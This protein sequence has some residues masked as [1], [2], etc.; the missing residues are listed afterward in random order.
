VCRYGTEFNKKKEAV[1]RIQ[2]A[3]RGRTA[4]KEIKQKHEAATK[5][6]AT[7]RGNQARRGRWGAAPA[8]TEVGA[9]KTAYLFKTQI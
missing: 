9:M 4:R 6:Q 1:T 3:H 2:S 5:V 8:D 7:V